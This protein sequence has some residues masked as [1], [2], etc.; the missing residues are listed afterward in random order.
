[1]LRVVLSRVRIPEPIANTSGRLSQHIGG[2]SCIVYRYML[3]E[4]KVALHWYRYLNGA[5]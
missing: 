4:S 5:N 2:R 3:N 1:M